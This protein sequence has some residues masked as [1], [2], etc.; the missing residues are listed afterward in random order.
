METLE[1]PSP[2]AVTS[3]EP[4]NHSLQRLLVYSNH[5]TYPQR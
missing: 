5:S 2:I 4:H 3:K 1:E